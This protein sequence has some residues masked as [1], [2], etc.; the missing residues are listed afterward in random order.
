M[1]FT[2]KDLEAKVVQLQT[3]VDAEQAEIAALLAQK[4]AA[5]LALQEINATLVAEGGTELERQA[6][7]ESIDAVIT[8][9]QSTVVVETPPVEEG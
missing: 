5:I 4:D 9:L 8:D 7:S 2:I 6:I 1:A 3:T